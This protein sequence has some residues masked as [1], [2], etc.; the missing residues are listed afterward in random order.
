VTR[1]RLGVAI[2]ARE[3]RAVLVR[4]D[5]VHWHESARF[6]DANTIAPALRDVLA[7]APR[8]SLGIRTSVTMSPAWV[9]V[10]PLFGLP[11]IRDARLAT[12]LV[13][14]NQQA[15]FLWNGSAAAIAEVRVR[16]DGATW[17]AA[18]DKHAIDEVARAL[19]ESKAGVRV[20]GATV[21]AVAAAFPN[22]A[23]DWSD[24]DTLFELESDGGG[25]SRVDRVADG[26]M[27]NRTAL[28]S[29]L[30]SLSHD[31]H[32]FLDAYAAALAPRRLPLSWRLESDETQLRRWVRARRA[33]VTVALS[34][35]GLFAAIGPGVRARGVARVA[36]AELLRNRRTQLELGTSESNLRR[37]TQ[38][39][40][41]IESFR[42]ERGKVT[43]V[44]GMLAR[45]VPESTAMLTLHVDSVEGAFTAIAPHVA[46]VLPELANEREIVAPRIVGSVT[47]EVIGSVHVE[48][49]SFRF[50]RLRVS[51]SVPRRTTP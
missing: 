35:M 5:V 46:D 27:A 26:E 21:V 43:H 36:D 20:V 17:G 16:H 37:V 15:F 10:K 32:Q 42:A 11:P 48:R 45:A 18:F 12:Q 33:A 22:R 30:S 34:A 49:A 4:G 7:R 14:E 51:T 39:L 19:R 40:N 29:P 47:R 1:G 13:R 38:S 24:G 31:A 8:A 2:G 28:P 44:L 9:Q 41:R 3:I 25:L 23:I 50:R 6:A